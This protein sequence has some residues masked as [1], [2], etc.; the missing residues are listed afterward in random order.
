M[1]DSIEDDVVN[2]GLQLVEEETRDVTTD[3]FDQVE[4]Q[5]TSVQRIKFFL[6]T[7]EVDGHNI[8][9]ST[10]VLQLNGNVFLSKNRL[11]RIKHST[12]FNNLD[13]CIQAISS[14]GSGL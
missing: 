14:C 13:N 11:T 5:E 8:Y 12:Q 9:K 3:L 1:G 4:D 10:L 6:L 2:D 7:V